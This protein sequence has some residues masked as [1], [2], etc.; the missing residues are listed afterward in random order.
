M[1]RGASRHTISAYHHDLLDAAKQLRERNI[2]SWQGLNSEAVIA[3]QTHLGHVY[4]P[5]TARRKMSAIRALLKFLKV[6]GFGPEV[7]LPDTGTF[8]ATRDLPRSLA[9]E[10]VQKLLEAVDLS[11]AGGLRDR[12]LMELLYGGGL[13][14]S[15]ALGLTLDALDLNEERLRVTGKRGKT[16]V[17]PLPTETVNWLRRY[18][19]LRKELLV[20]P[21]QEVFVADRGKPLR[22]DTFFRRLSQY[23]IKAGIVESVGPHRLR[24]SYAV[25][26]LRGGADLRSVQ[27]LLGHASIATT[28]VYTQLDMTE[29]RKKYSN[30]H[31]R[32]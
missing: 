20:K 13:R 18:L 5:R 29:V 19:D 9:E 30:A 1:E 24:H 7:D 31:P 26:L 32:R 25:A 4:S 17:V 8:K 27:E 22:R 28:Q 16:R 15:E 12:A 2:A 11:T 23:A 3:I 6:R 14:I 21:I 10:P